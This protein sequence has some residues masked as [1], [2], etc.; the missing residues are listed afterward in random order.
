M[1]VAIDDEEAAIERSVI[2]DPDP[3]PTYWK[4]GPDYILFVLV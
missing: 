2:Q 4:G 1:R 3:W